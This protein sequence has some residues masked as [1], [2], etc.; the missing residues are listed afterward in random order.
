M[1]IIQQSRHETIY[2]YLVIV[3]LVCG[4]FSCET[5]VSQRQIEAMVSNVKFEKFLHNGSFAGQMT[6]NN[7]F[8]VYIRVIRQN[9]WMFGM[10]YDCIMAFGLEPGQ[11]MQVPHDPYERNIRFEI[12]DS[13]NH[14]IGIMRMPR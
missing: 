2:E 4:C 14:L 13:Q 9:A 10:D 8:T 6:N 12:Y 3:L 11:V 5:K 7:T 1:K